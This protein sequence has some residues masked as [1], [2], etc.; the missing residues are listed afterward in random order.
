[1]WYGGHLIQ[2]GELTPGELT[3]FL[4]YAFGIASSVGTLG[5]LYGGYKELQGASARVFQILD[6]APTVRDAPGARPL[7]RPRGRLVFER[8]LLRP[9]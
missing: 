2:A 7:G 5:H 3:S 1:M 8:D 9:M 6:T 4:L